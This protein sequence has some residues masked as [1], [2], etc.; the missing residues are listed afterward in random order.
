MRYRVSPILHVIVTFT[1]TV[2]LVLI[3]IEL[4]SVADVVRDKV[5]YRVI[6]VHALSA[7][8]YPRVFAEGP[9]LRG[10]VCFCGRRTRDYTAP[11]EFAVARR[12]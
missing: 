3:K 11:E 1:V 12:N 8:G 6:C 4:P 9:E 5:F 10:K 7:T 2:I